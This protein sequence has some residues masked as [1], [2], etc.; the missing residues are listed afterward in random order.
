MS[1]FDLA[2]QLYLDRIGLS[3]DKWQQ[4][5]QANEERGLRQRWSRERGAAL[6]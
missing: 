1:A 2:P 4:V 6:E 3:L 5:G